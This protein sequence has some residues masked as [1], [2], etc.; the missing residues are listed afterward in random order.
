MS[1]PGVPDRILMAYFVELDPNMI[2]EK[3]V[4]ENLAASQSC[5]KWKNHRICVKTQ[6]SAKSAE[7]P[8]KREITVFL[9]GC[10][11]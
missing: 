1:A 11:F 6:K 4:R 5:E 8:A 9:V 10:N 3:T 2:L 7:N